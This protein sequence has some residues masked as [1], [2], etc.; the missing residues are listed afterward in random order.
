MQHKPNIQS[1]CCSLHNTTVD[2][3]TNKHVKQRQWTWTSAD[4]TS[5]N[6]TVVLDRTAE[7]ALIE[8]HVHRTGLQPATTISAVDITTQ[9]LALQY[10]STSTADVTFSIATNKNISNPLQ[11]FLFAPA[12]SSGHQ[13]LTPDL[14]PRH[15]KQWALQVPKRLCLL[16]PTKCNIKHKTITAYWLFCLGRNHVTGTNLAQNDYVSSLEKEC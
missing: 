15:W 12:F 14:L 16:N 9:S 10:H 6:R 2:T 7:T 3:Q 5:T 11:N 13:C 8:T 4:K 1:T